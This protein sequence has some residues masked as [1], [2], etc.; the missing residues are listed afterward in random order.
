MRR[1]DAQARCPSLTMIDADPAR[2]ARHFEVAVRALGELVPVVGVDDPGTAM[3]GA[4]GPS[5]WCGGDEA[6][7]ERVQQLVLGAL[8]AADSPLCIE[9]VGIGI[10][11]GR[12]AAAIAAH[13]S[14][15]HGAPVVVPA[16]VSATAAMLAPVGV[17]ALHDLGGVGIG[18]VDLLV[19]LGLARLG[20]LAALPRRDLATRFGPE[21][22]FAHRLASGD[23]DRHPAGRTPAPDL[24]VVE[25]FEDPMLQIAPL[26]FSARRLAESLCGALGARGECC[27]HLVVEAET[28]HG[29]RSER[30]WFRSGGMSVAAMVERVRWQLE[31]WVNQPGGLSSGVV[32]LRLVPSLVRPMEG[33]QLG[34][35]GEASGADEQAAR[36]V[37]RL[38]GLVGPDA[39][40]VPEWGGGRD[41]V[42]RYRWVCAAGVDIDDRA[43]RTRALQPPAQPWPGHIAAPSPAWVADTPIA[44]DVRD[45]TGAAVR[46]DGRGGISAAPVHAVLLDVSAVSGASGGDVTAWAGPWPVDERWWDTARRRRRARLQLLLDSGEAWLVSIEHGTWRLEARYC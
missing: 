39:V 38:V 20:D 6:L 27:T 31:G 21:G 37:A 19:R 18:T 46:V 22:E 26:V 16:G 1:R 11:D 24:A 2:D 10:A 25:T 30:E 8:R 44:I 13:L 15:R 41:P 5:R 17:R 33:R 42:E 12:F 34:F 14:V 29:E 36:A 3:F 32:L 7:A 9:G 28:D 4:R 35:W 40:W 43:A 45:A 23:D